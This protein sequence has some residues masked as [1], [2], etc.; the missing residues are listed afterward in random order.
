[1][2]EDALKACLMKISDTSRVRLGAICRSKASCAIRPEAAPGKPKDGKQNYEAD[3]HD[4]VISHGSHLGRANLL[5]GGIV[6]N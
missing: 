6:V 4:L 1:M 2:G 5:I 3:I